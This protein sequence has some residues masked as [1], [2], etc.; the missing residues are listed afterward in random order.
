VATCV[1]HD[2]SVAAVMADHGHLGARC[3][4]DTIRARL[5]HHMTGATSRSLR[6]EI[7]HLRSRLPTK[8]VP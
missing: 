1:E 8:G 7:P 3:G 4:P 6:E 2:W 5:A